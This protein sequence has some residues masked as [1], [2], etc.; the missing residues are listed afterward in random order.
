MG[1]RSQVNCV[2]L[3]LGVVGS[4]VA[5]ALLEKSDNFTHRVGLPLTLKRVLVRDIE[6]DRTITLPSGL[7][8]DKP[9]EALTADC[10]IVVEVMGGEQPALDYITRSLSAGRRVVT[11]NKE[12]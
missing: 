7:L 11:A 8:T 10:D 5:R 6:R 1:G 12:V 3:G 9:A 4:G 2:L